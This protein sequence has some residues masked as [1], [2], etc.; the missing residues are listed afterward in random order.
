M[1]VGLEL[2]L[3]ENIALGRA[4]R[5]V[6]VRDLARQ[7]EVLGF[8]SLW[9]Y[10]HL[11]YRDGENR[12]HG[13]WEGWT[14]LSALA[15]ATARVEIGTLVTCTAFRNPALLAKMATTLDEVSGGR[16]TLGL[17][18]GWNEVEFTAFGIPFDRR[19]TRFEEAL[20]II[21]PL[22]REGRV[23]FEGAYHRAFNCDIV[24]RGPRHAGSSILIAAFGPRM[25][26]LAARYADS[27]NGGY[28]ASPHELDVL[29][30]ALLDACVDVGRDPAT[31]SITAELKVANPDL[32]PPPSLFCG[33]YVTGST[34]ELAATLRT[35]AKAGF[36][37]LMCT[38][39][40]HTPEAVARVGQALKLY[41]DVDA[42]PH[43][44]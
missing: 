23:S 2:L 36:A 15:A 7:A 1:K 35:F 18:A 14:I 17:G 42:V 25:L 13:V 16:L 21:V 38:V 39:S 3:G 19:V 30:A 29:R 34:E 4:P 10:D 33:S 41:R 27:W 44:R 31:M 37:D 43:G 12:P 20:Q 22:V 28:V 32:A 11:L 9:V 40:P 8:D 24:P 26:R 6:E 5:Y